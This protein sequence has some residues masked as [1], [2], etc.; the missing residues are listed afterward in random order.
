M[1]INFEIKSIEK[2]LAYSISNKY[3]Y[4]NTINFEII[5]LFLL[6]KILFQIFNSITYFLIQT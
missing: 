3:I 6:N 2:Y 5:N 4:L 1:E